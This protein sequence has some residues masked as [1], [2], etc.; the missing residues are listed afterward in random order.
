MAERSSL[1]Q[2]IQIGVETTPGT[3]VA[4]NKKLLSIGIEPNISVETNPFRPIGNKF[5]SLSTLGKEW[6]EAAIT[7]TG[8]FTELQYL[9]S[10]VMNTAVITTP[11]GGTTSRQWV[12]T[13]STTADDVPKTFTVEHG[14]GV[15]ADRFA[16]GLVTEFGMAFSR[17]GI[18][19]S[20]S[21]LGRA[22]E[23]GVTM[24]TSP[25]SGALV[26]IL[27]TQVS[28]YLDTTAA[29]LGT[30]KLT[31]LISGEF[32]LGSRFGPVWVLDAANPSFVN[33][34]ETE[35]D[36]HVT[37][38]LQANTAGMA[39]LGNLRAGDIR[40]LR[41]EAIGGI[42][43][44]AIPYRF[45]LDTAVSISDTGGFSD[46]DGVY[47]IEFTGLGI[48]DAT[49]GKAVQATLVNTSTAL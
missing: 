36:L 7:G 37:L 20:G 9:L 29:G 49:W 30:T 42:I 41:I 21:M 6:V 45:A 12:F 3:A 31:R 39:L 23:D 8:T 26:P 2:T 18:E 27:P 24:T 35:P 17:D 22:L 14:S 44:G 48:H 46:A 19:V 15:R 10:S 11:G 25:T 34:I 28:V 47:A 13:P 16:Y 43:E 1:N 38:L 32:S 33:H 5:N 40:F 4:A